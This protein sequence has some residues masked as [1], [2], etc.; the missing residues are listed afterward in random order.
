MA[1]SGSV[2]YRSGVKAAG[3]ERFPQNMLITA[4]SVSTLPSGCSL[5]IQQ[6]IVGS[7]CI[8]VLIK[9][10]LHI[11]YCFWGVSQI[12]PLKIL[13]VLYVSKCG[14]ANNEV[15]LGGSIIYIL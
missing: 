7:F 14:N 10:L 8:I 13:A 11:P 3:I 4:R 9:K 1:D 2:L 12:V 6:T 15:M 5:C